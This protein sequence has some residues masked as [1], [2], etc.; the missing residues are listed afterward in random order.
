MQMLSEIGA[1]VI[2]YVLGAIPFGLL[3][4]KIKTGKDIRDVESGRTGG[5]NAVRAAGLGAGLLTAILDVLKGAGAVWIAQALVPG[6]HLVHILAGITAI[7][8][9]NY[10]IFLIERNEEGS[11]R[12]RGGAGGAPAFGGAMGLWL[13][14]FPVVFA[15]GG[16]VWSDPAQPQSLGTILADRQLAGSVEREDG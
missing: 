7:V 12:L 8:G 14:M 15:V 9:H 13:G 4:V 5:T 1:V 2:G 11:I 3:I 16:L 6:N 10:S